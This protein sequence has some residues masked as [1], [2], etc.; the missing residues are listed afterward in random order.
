MLTAP[1][2]GVEL[3]DKA[4][5]Y[6]CDPARRAEGEQYLQRVRMTRAAAMADCLLTMRHFR[7]GGLPLSDSGIPVGKNLCMLRAYLF[8]SVFE[9][10]HH[11]VTLVF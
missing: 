4:L 2:R 5:D 8:E 3:D 7:Y 9:I 11:A 6:I 10:I 1:V